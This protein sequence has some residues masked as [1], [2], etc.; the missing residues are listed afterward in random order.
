MSSSA[1]AHSP[2]SGTFVGPVG[3]KDE[4]LGFLRLFTLGVV[5]GPVARVLGAQ[6]FPPCVLTN[7]VKECALKLG[8][9]VQA[10]KFQHLGN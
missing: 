9:M 7:K 6:P 10:Y 3:C 1:P 2:L 4:S 8:A 5:W